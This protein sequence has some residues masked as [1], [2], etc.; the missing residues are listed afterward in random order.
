MTPL[1]RKRCIDV[2]YEREHSTIKPKK[3]VL[4][5][6]DWEDSVDEREEF[7]EEKQIIPK[8]NKNFLSEFEEM[9]GVRKKEDGQVFESC[10]QISIAENNSEQIEEETVHLRRENW[11]EGEKFEEMQLKMPQ[12][13]KETKWSRRELAKGFYDPPKEEGWEIVNVHR[14]GKNAGF[15]VSEEPLKKVE[16]GFVADYLYIPNKMEQT[17]GYYNRRLLGGIFK[18]IVCNELNQSINSSNPKE[19][20]WVLQHLETT[21][22]VQ[23]RGKNEFPLIFSSRG[24]KFYDI[25]DQVAVMNEEQIRKALK[26]LKN[27]TGSFLPLRKFLYQ[28]YDKKCVYCG[29]AMEGLR[30]VVEHY[31]GHKQNFKQNVKDHNISLQIV[32]QSQIKATQIGIIEEREKDEDDLSFLRLSCFKCNTNKSKNHNDCGDCLMNR[33]NIHTK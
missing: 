28:K 22:S 25:H 33:K 30:F 5:V 4:D 24:V 19:V 9:E 23:S 27:D 14:S 17:R 15:V 29:K 32:S 12:G 2:N 8:V 7:R 26:Y 3:I 10:T 13:W 18:Q 1:K 11:V 6:T 20:L 21:K 16:S 31:Y